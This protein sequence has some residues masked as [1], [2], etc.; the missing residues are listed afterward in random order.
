MIDY[1]VVLSLESCFY[2]FATDMNP[3][4]KFLFES[5]CTLSSE[6]DM[7]AFLKD[8]L[9]VWEIEEFAQRL[10]IAKRLH[11][12]QT[13]KNIEQET[14]VSSTT[15][16]RIAKFLKGPYQWYTKVLKKLL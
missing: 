16:A 13:Y 4:I 11:Q 15:I 1:C 9:T 5:L 14:G 12:W 10:D 6:D 3:K 8:L 2:P 7:E